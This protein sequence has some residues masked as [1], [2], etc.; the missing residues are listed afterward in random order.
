MIIRVMRA[1]GSGKTTFINLISGSSLRVG[2]GLHSCT[3]DIQVSQ[4]FELERRSVML[5]DTP[6]FD[7]TSKSDT[8]ILGTIASFLGTAYEKNTKLAGVI[9]IQ[10]ISDNR[11]G[12]ISTRNFRMF[13]KLCGDDTLKN[14]I[15]M[16][17]MW[18][19]VSEEVALRN[20]ARLLRHYNTL[21]SAENILKCVI[22]NHP[23]ALQIQRELVEEKKAMS[24]TAAGG[25]LNE[26]FRQ[27]ARKHEEDMKKLEEEM[28][29]V[30]EE[31]DLKAEEELTEARKK[32]QAEMRRI[33]E[34]SEKLASD[35]SAERA[36]FERQFQEQMEAARQEASD[37]QRKIENLESHLE[38]S[39]SAGEVKALR[40][41][42]EELRNRRHDGPGCIVQ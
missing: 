41:E 3:A 42:L 40:S 35:Y 16:T 19:E 10:R 1:T 15:L 6:G 7:D 34:N 36:K 22:S 25:I 21:E 11:M 2:T 12:G 26:E 39:V 13:R 32:L 14:V 17:N 18:G 20:G 23:E 8:D 4:T 5:I 37:N 29:E 31:R 28:K 38:G 24:E 27:L 33:E 30:I 9:Y